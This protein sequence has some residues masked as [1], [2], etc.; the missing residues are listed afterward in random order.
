MRSLILFFL[1]TF[2][3]SVTAQTNEPI[4]GFWGLEF[5]E[6]KA[7]VKTKIKHTI[8]GEDE[9]TI[10]IKEVS[11]GGNRYD[12][13]IV[14]FFKNRL[15]YGLFS[16]EIE[17]KDDAIDFMN[18]LDEKISSKY[19]NPDTK[20]DNIYKFFKWVDVNDNNILLGISPAETIGYRIMLIYIENAIYQEKKKSEINDF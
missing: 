5:G 11:F 15:Y 1:L 10:F 20:D 19:G 12:A 9:N 17:S 7:K 6:T 3:L 13:C 2:T 14:E 18:S 8:S 16:K 4:R